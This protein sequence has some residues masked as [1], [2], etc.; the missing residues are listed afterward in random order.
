MKININ[1]SNS[2]FNSNSKIPNAPNPLLLPS[3][4][5]T[6][7]DVKELEKIFKE[8]KRKKQ[9]TKTKNKKLINQTCV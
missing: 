9:K 5:D 8:K 4:P 1:N 6:P 3:I 7:P 2:N